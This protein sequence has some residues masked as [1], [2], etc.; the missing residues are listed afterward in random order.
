VSQIAETRY[1][2]TADGVHIAYQVVGDGPLDLLF[3]PGFASHVE[4]QWEE[5]RQARF[6]ERLAS[7]ARLIRFDKRG[8][9]LSDPVRTMPTLEERMDDMTAVMEAAGSS[10]AALLG[11]SEGGPLG[12]VFAASRPEKVNALIIWNSFARMLAAADFPEGMVPAALEQF[13]ALMETD[14]GTGVFVNLWVPTLAADPLFRPWWNRFE[15]LALSPG[16]AVELMRIYS[17]TDVRAVLPTIRVPTLV[18][19]SPGDPVM[20]TNRGRYF[21][22]HI[23]GARYRELPTYDHFSWVDGDVIA[24]EIEEFLTGSRHAAEPDRVLATVLFT[25]IVASTARAS[26]IGDLRWTDLLDAY[27][28]AVGRQLARFRGRQV[29]STGDGTLATF[30]GPARAIQCASAIRDATRSLGLQVRLGLH[31]GE[32]EQRGDDIGGIAVH[33]AARVQALAGPGEVLVSRTVVDLVAGSGIEFSDR[34]EHELKGV[35]GTWRLFA[36]EG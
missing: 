36:V 3:I 11:L 35:P 15:R 10:Q 14:W 20:P 2:K 9:G 7:F 22:D 23:A 4:F 31:T 18:F 21:A 1:A 28:Q 25:D 33:T 6:F 17:A 34:G 24:L 16:A 30:D 13:I 32:V 19:Q 5:V 12:A 26:E 29:K 8:A 27:D